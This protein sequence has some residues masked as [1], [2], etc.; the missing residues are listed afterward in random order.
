MTPASFLNLRYF[1]FGQC[2]HY[3]PFDE[4]VTLEEERRDQSINFKARLVNS[5]GNA[6]SHL[7]GGLFT[8]PQ[9]ISS[10]TLPR[11]NNCPS[12]GCKNCPMFG[13]GESP[14]FKKRE[15][16]RLAKREKKRLLQLRKEQQK[17]AEF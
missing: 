11:C 5:D 16:E 17:S 12:K 7:T 4:L 6:L 3:I 9:E 10:N 1:S 14:Y 2:I 8:A 13:V 15:E